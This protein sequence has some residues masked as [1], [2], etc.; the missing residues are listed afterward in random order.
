MRIHG[1]FYH[2]PHLTKSCKKSYP[3]KTRVGFI[4]LYTPCKSAGFLLFF[5]L[6]V[7]EFFAV[8]LDAL[9]GYLYRRIASAELFDY[10][11][12]ALEHLVY[13]EEVHYLVE[14]MSRQAVDVSVDVVGGV[15]EGDGNNLVVQLAAVYHA[16][17]AD[18]GD[19]HQRQRVEG[20]GAQHQHIQRVA[21]IGECARNKAVVGGVVG[22]GVEN[23]VELEHTGL[24]VHLVFVL[25]ALGYLDTGDKIVALYSL[26]SYVVPYVHH[27]SF[28]PVLSFYYISCAASNQYYNDN[29]PRF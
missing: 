1:R 21:V 26:R 7:S 12:L 9:I 19:A 15:G 8:R 27:G 5:V 4:A 11:L 6:F 10:R 18:G 23:A 22:R 29:L 24:L 14:N 25:A 16:H 20:L 2:R 3:T 28:P 17:G 13:T